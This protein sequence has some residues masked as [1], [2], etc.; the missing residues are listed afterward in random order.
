MDRERIQKMAQRIA[1]DNDD[2]ALV[3]VDQA[4]DDLIALLTELDENLTEIQADTPEQK[5]AVKG[6]QDI[7]ET[8]LAPYTA[9]F[10]KLMDA[11][12]GE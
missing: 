11:F 9:D 12:T 3:N 5:K 4:V 10:A 7:L 8:A 6:M 1:A 2:K